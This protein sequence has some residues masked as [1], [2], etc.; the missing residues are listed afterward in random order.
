MSFHSKY[1]STMTMTSIWFRNFD[2]SPLIFLCSTS[3]WCFW[4]SWRCWSAEFSALSSEKK[5][6]RPWDL[7]WHHQSKCMEVV[8][9][10]PTLGIS[11]SHAWDVAELK[12]SGIGVDEF[13]QHVVKRLTEFNENP[14]KTTQI[15]QIPISLDVTML[16]CSLLRN[17]LRLWARQELS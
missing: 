3:F 17:V 12:A 1:D 14:A 8:V 10:W 9:R 16:D 7:K 5:L 6:N 4:Y 15:C 2:K 11:P 13:P